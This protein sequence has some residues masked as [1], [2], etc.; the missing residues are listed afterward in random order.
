MKK[1]IAIM[2][3]LIMALSLFACAGG[4]DATEPSKDAPNTDGNSS[5]APSQSAEKANIVLVIP[6]SLGDK[7]FS[8]MVWAGVQI[9][10]EKNPDRIGNIK[11][12]EL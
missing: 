1:L 2:L 11:C 3:V 12:I 7:A 9:A 8:D 4:N 10:K 6:N 5:D